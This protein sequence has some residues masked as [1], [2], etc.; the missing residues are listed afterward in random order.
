MSMRRDQLGLGGGFVVTFATLLESLRVR[1]GFADF[2]INI[3][4]FI[5]LK[6]R[7][8][9]TA[10]IHVEAVLMTQTHQ[11]TFGHHFFVLSSSPLQNEKIVSLNEF[12]C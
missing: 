8:I 1:S 6:K 2:N 10:G 4:S 3:D 7:L 9:L 11:Y 12:R 5:G